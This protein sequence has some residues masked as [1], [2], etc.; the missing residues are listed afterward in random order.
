[1]YPVQS[2]MSALINFARAWIHEQGQNTVEIVYADVDRVRYVRRLLGESGDMVL[3]LRD[4]AKLEMRAV[5]R[6]QEIYDYIMS[7]VDADTRERSGF[8]QG[9]E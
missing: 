7:K 6:F 1:M 2:G 5:P 3:E 9:N 8:G 4:G